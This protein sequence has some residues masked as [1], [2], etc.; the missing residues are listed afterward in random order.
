[1][2]TIAK[3][4][5]VDKRT[6]QRSIRTLAALG[7]LVVSEGKGPKGTHRYRILLRGGESPPGDTPPRRDAT[8]ASD[9]KKGGETP[10]EPSGTVITPLTP[11]ERGEHPDHC[12]KHTKYRNGCNSRPNCAEMRRRRIAAERNDERAQ[13]AALLAE[14]RQRPRDPRPKETA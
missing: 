12:T 7:E 4:A 9:P 8:V 6:A 3:K 2:A 5:N 14:L 11:R 1:M 13:S 10:P